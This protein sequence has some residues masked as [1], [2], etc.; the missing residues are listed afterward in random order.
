MENAV[1]EKDAP[2][3]PQEAH[4]EPVLTNASGHVQEL[5]RKYGFR[6][7]CLAVDIA[8]DRSASIF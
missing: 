4:G 8:D 3:S 1:G 7:S 6:A 5:D 2:D